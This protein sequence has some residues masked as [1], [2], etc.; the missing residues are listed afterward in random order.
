M[1]DDRLRELEEWL[2]RDCGVTLDD[3]RPAS[4]DAS[5]RRYFRVLSGGHSY[6]AMDAPPAQEDSEPFLRIAGWLQAIGLTAPRVLEADLGAGFLLLTDLG[7]E[8]YLQRL[9]AAPGEADRLYGAA[10]RALVRLQRGGARHAAE[11]PPYDRAFLHTEMA[12]FREW[13]CQRHLALDW[14][15]DD[16][17][18]WDAVT[19]RLAASAA[20]QPAVFVH[21]DYHSRNLMVTAEPPGILDFQDA[22]HGPV[23]YDLVSLLK[24]CYITWPRERVLG[25]VDEYRQAARAA[26]LRTGDGAH[27]AGGF[28]RAF[29]LMGVQRHLKAA[30]IFARLWH[31]DGK[32]GYLA[33]VPRTL[34]YVT[35]LR[36]DYPE[37]DWICRL[38]T[39]RVLPALPARAP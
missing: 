34:A 38:I 2:V 19:E 9:R 39:E 18:A 12:L 20:A 3:L 25:W 13:L 31:R 36:A 27:E 14:S 10:I 33:D 5:F 4:A 8:L 24:D 17:A 7:D 6:I 30:G 28:L 1:R 32:P 35:A 29:D 37:L 21:R 23:T 15:A 26:G 16:A 22:M 11:L